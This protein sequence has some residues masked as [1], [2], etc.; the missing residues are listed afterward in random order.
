MYIDN[1]LEYHIMYVFYMFYYQLHYKMENRQ[2]KG[3][4]E[5]KTVIII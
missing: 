1:I 2:V 5:I 3:T 4:N